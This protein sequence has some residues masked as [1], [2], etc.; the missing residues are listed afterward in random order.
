M[1]R[2]LILTQ[3]ADTKKKSKNKL[4]NNDITVEKSLPEALVG[5]FSIHSYLS[6]K[7]T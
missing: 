6:V 5:K 1:C 2:N 3:T 4:R 7:D